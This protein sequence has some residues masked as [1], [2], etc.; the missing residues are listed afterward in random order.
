MISIELFNEY[1]DYPRQ[2]P[3]TLNSEFHKLNCSFAYTQKTNGS[4][5]ANGKY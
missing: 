3:K 2:N 4:S 1:T 5:K